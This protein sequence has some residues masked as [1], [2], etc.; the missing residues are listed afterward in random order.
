[1]AESGAMHGQ[2]Q[3]VALVGAGSAERFGWGS[4]Q[5]LC[6]GKLVP[7]AQMTF[8]YV[9]IEPGQKNQRHVHP[10]SDEVLYLI[11]GELDHTLG[12]AVYHLTPG[13]AIHIPVGV[14]HD[15]TNTSAVV[16]RM[17]VAYPT[18]DRQ[19]APSGLGGE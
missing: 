16:A 11:E 8:G 10:S 15:A 4:I 5:W 12:E 17:V 7:G 6:S 19:M 1:M 3:R 18:G 2:P 13:A 9:E 14:A